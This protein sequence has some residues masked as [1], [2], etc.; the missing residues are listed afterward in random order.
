MGG[1]PIP[2]ACFNFFVTL[3]R[4]YCEN[5]FILL[6]LF[7]SGIGGRCYHFQ[8]R[9]GLEMTVVI[10]EELKYQLTKLRIRYSNFLYRK[11]IH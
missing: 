8:N 5:K 3:I 6:F 1:P 2:L 9:I 11:Q 10:M 7:F 4:N